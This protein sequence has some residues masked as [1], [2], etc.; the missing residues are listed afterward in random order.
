MQLKPLAEQVIAITGASSG[1]G[2]LTA[3]LAAKRGAKVLL[4]ARNGDALAEIVESIRKNGGSAEYAV[5]DVGNRDEL[6]AAA[7]KAIACFGRIDTWVNNAGVAIYAKLV[8]T[9]LDEHEQMMRTNYFGAV[10]GAQVAVEHLQE[11]GGALITV[12][13]IVGDMP[14]A[15]MGA[16]AASKHALVA[17]IRAL[18][19]ELQADGAPISVTLIKP[20]G[21]ATPIAEH[22]ANHR[23]GAPKIPPPVYDPALVAEAILAAA[24]KPTREVSVGGIG[25]LQVLF[26]NHFPA[27]FERIAPVIGP[28][29]QDRDKPAS[30]SHN[31]FAPAADGM[32]RSADQTGRSFSVYDT[33][34]RSNPLS[35]GVALAAGVAGIG[36][37]VLQRH[38]GARG[39]VDRAL[40]WEKPT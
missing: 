26:A 39:P 28:L 1:I 23:A 2:L 27:L 3:R 38:R 11:R 4:I 6:R 8:D 16:Y 13:S 12:A 19:I 18:R 37:T 34:V 31:L 10:N 20:S 40:A 35:I 21:M 32:E 9:P 36:L 15:V 25:V 24:Q 22:A 14:S 33:L 17:F 7:D 29:V 5:A 30:A